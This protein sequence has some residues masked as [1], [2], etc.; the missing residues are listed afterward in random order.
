MR[1]IT[2]LFVIMT[3]GV[4]ASQTDT[5]EETR[6]F[7]L[8]FTPFPYEVSMEAVRYVYDRITENADLIV[9]HFDNG[10][11]WN[12][13]LK[14]EPYA[15]EILSDWNLRLSL[16]PPDHRMLLTVTPINFL[17]T[18]LANYRGEREDMPLQPPFDG[19]S[20]DH[21]DVIRAFTQYC[22]DIIAYFEPD[23]FLMGIEVNL[24]MKER[25]DLWDAY[26]VL[27][28]EAYTTLKANHPELPI[29]VSLTGFDL[30]RGYTE[31][32]SA[33][34]A[35]ALSDITQYTD[36][37]ALSLY[38]YMTSYMTNAIP[39][40]AFEQLDALIDKP[41]AVSE[42]GYPAQPFKVSVGGN[43]QFNGTPEL[44]AEWISLVL[45]SA[46]RY[47]FSFVVVFVVR[48]YDTIWE[49]LGAVEDITIA[50]RDTGM[51]DEAGTA[52]PALDIW[53]QWLARPVRQE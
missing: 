2:L 13:A 3:G 52:R 22:E 6:H 16:T 15:D 46:Q 36:I 48:D 24:L 10:V 30:L 28:R 7:Y 26:M 18:G 11:P 41:L 21:P 25:P 43:V 34:Q 19:Y 51:Y 23:Y 32:D 27:Q 4:I 33:N 8:G 39:T 47:E 53:R 31:A 20:F 5:S 50:W 37:V 49:M 44:Q 1:W 17:R 42:T 14:G 9:H 38:P 40:D 35:R 12:E 29:M 45:E